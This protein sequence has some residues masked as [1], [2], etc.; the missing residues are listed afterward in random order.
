MVSSRLENETRVHAIEMQYVAFET[1]PLENP[2]DFCMCWNI[3]MTE[4]I[5][6]LKI[7]FL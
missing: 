6:D 4:Y 3:A 7:T 1:A 2:R 5:C